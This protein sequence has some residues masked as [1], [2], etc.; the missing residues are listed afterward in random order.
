MSEENTKD[1]K[2]EPSQ[3]QQA[4][5][6]ATGELD[7]VKELLQTYGKRILLW[8]VAAVVGVS[9]G[10]GY[11]LH[12]QANR[13]RASEQLWNAKSVQDLEIVAEDSSSPMAPLA[14]A[15][16]SRRYYDTRNWDLALKK[17][18]DLQ[19][20]FPGQSLVDFAGMAEMGK[21]H[22]L[23]ARGQI[24]EAAEGF[25][26]FAKTHPK[27]YLTPLALLGEA[28]CMEELGNF[29]EAKARYEE[30]IVAYAGT[31]WAER[32]DGFLKTID[33]RAKKGAVSATVPIPATLDQLS[34]APVPT[35]ASAAVP[36]PTNVEIKLNLP[37]A[38][39]T[40]P[41]QP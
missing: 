8:V 1:Q 13:E 10:V 14:L 3:P 5:R 24:Q 30:F 16:V 27:H 40:P 35:P 2:Q 21:L 33:R 36:V 20:R 22:S 19:K 17:Y 23:E 18:D 11:R 32:A 39:P 6:L 37:V 26:V 15:K 29:T 34:P 12:K 41:Q 25:A 9:L 28:R 4:P 38:P 31:P 7:D